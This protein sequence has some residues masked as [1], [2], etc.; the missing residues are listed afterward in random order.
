MSHG[1]EDVIE[2]AFGQ[3]GRRS[4]LKRFAIALG[5]TGAGTVLGAGG[6]QAFGP[7]PPPQIP[8]AAA[9]FDWFRDAPL[10]V[11]TYY[12][13]SLSAHINLPNGA[14]PKWSVIAADRVIVGVA[15]SGDGTE[16]GSESITAEGA[17]TG[18]ALAS[19]GA[20]QHDAHTT[21]LV[22]GALAGTALSGPVNHASD[23]SHIHAFTEPATHA[24]KNWH[25]AFILK[26]V[27]A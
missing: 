6:S 24:I 13:G 18:A 27:V 20:H 9:G 2:S 7:Q 21:I 5:Y 25:K 3:Q 8:Q 16:G 15:A 11:V 23:G 4:F 22:I 12:E 1:E 10:G 17:H 14:S 26:K 19:A